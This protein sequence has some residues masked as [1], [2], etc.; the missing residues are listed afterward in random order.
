MGDGNGTNKPN[1]LHGSYQDN[2]DTQNGSTTFG[3]SLSPPNHSM[4]TKR[5]SRSMDVKEQ[6]ESSPLISPTRRSN[7]SVETPPFS[8]VGSPDQVD[9]WSEDHT[10]ETKSSWYLLLL[11]LAIGGLQISW[12]VEL[13]YGSPYL[14]GLGISKSL[15]ALVWI[16]GPLS[17]VLVQPYVGIKSDRSRSK[18][19]KRRPYIVGGALATIVSL[20]C[21]AWAREIVAT[22]LHIFGVD[23]E[24]RGVNTVAIVLAVLLIYVLDVAI[25]ASKSSPIRTHLSKKL[26]GC[27]VQ[28][29]IRAFIVDNA[30]PHQQNDANAWASRVSGVGNILGYLSGYVNLPKIMPFFGNTQFKVLCVLACFALVITISISCLSIKERDPRMDGEPL[31]QESGVIAFFSNLFRSMTRLPPQISKVCQVQFFAW[32]AYFPFLFY[33][34]TY[35]GEIYAEPFFAANPN[36]TPAEVD[37]T[38]ERGTR[39]GSFALLI[40]AFTT[41][42][43]S[44]LLPIMVQPTF[45]PPSA[46]PKTPLTPALTTPGSVS[47][48]EYFGC[49]S[50]TSLPS[51]FSK[52]K[53]KGFFGRACNMLP[54]CRVPGLTLRRTWIISHLFFALAMFLTFAISSTKGA[55]VLVAFIG[56]PWA[57][58][59]WAP[60]AIIAAEIGKRDAIRRHKIQPP[61]TENGQLLASG[62]D[63]AE[64]A[65]QAG[66]VLGIHNVA[67]S[68]PQVLATLVSSVIFKA[69][70]KPRG[71]PGDDSVAWVLRL[72]GLAALVAAYLA[73]RIDDVET[74]VSERNPAF[75]GGGH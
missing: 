36:M 59:N 18:W 58:T 69:L 71:S 45:K 16:A 41:L 33:T 14:L 52:R 28:A 20:I 67:I 31:P 5:A 68:S 30:P 50:E 62:E 65:D 22:F 10:Q 3:S 56:I 51:S 11:T 43:A 23:R 42:G 26:I 21:L 6:N 66:V 15:L 2:A 46:D 37:E 40:F 49:R 7:E 25:N 75:A 17:G 39:K 73:T 8:P 12:S 4:D 19:G 57:L 38:W 54:S 34:T 72:G 61:P 74:E 32:F 29:G 44:I 70:Q 1:T 13:A 9:D 60:F 55:T 48:D 24:A 27:A 35:I 53:N 47:N 64:G 63:P